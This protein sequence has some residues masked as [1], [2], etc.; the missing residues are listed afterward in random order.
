[1]L[2]E[3]FMDPHKVISE[4][5]S[6]F[7]S[8]ILPYDLVMFF[9]LVYLNEGVKILYRM[10]YGFFKFFKPQMKE[11]KDLNGLK[12]A[13][14]HRASNFS[15]TDRRVFIQLCFK[16]SFTKIRE[17]FS[18]QA[19][20]IA[21]EVQAYIGN[22]KE[23]FLPVANPPSKITDDRYF[24]DIYTWIPAS[25]R[26]TN[27]ELIYANYRDGTALSNLIRNSDDFQQISNIMLIE[28][29]DHYKFGVFLPVG[30]RNTRG[31]FGGDVESFLFTL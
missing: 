30:F 9:F 23:V 31:E 3:K 27:P 25:C 6:C 1:M 15:Q 28:T 10:G 26:I 21:D 24:E 12:Y 4:M 18:K 22:V 5:F 2:E 7:F 29:D 13:V 16:L 14:S 11:S 19:M 20:K 17:C 8:N